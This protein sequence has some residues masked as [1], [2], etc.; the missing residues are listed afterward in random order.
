MSYFCPPVNIYS[1]TLICSSLKLVETQ[2]P[3]KSVIEGEAKLISNFD[4]DV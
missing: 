1:K 3:K 4:L 2:K